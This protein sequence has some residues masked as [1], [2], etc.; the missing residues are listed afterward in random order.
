[1]NK[2]MILNFTVPRKEDPGVKF[3]YDHDKN[4]NV[5][6][7]N[8]GVMPFIDVSVNDL[9]LLT[10][11]AIEREEDDAE[12]RMIELETKTFVEREEDDDD[13]SKLFLELMTKTKIE[14]ES[15][16]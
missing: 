4:L 3:F 9:E 7:T 11:T 5:L 6:K 8:T 14:R 1:M 10:K 2:P 15:D 13:F 16:D 12:V